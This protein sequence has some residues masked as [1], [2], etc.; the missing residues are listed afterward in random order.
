MN[1]RTFWFALLL[2]TVTPSVGV[3]I[4]VY[5]E[6]TQNDTG[7]TWKTVNEISSEELV[8]VDL[9]TETPRHAQFSY[10]PAEP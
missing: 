4:H 8:A 6:E 1:W 7:R 3:C 9:A 10:L 2:G 5:A